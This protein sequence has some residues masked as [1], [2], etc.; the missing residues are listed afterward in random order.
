MEKKKKKKT[1]GYC[2][3]RGRS[4]NREPN[5]WRPGE[6]LT[7]KDHDL[8]SVLIRRYN[9]LGYVPSQRE[10]PNARAIKKRFRIWND[11]VAA[12]GLPTCHTSIQGRIR[13]K[14]QEWEDRMQEI[15]S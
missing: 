7:A 13:A 4:Y 1:G 10:A 2:Y 3:Y 5:L 12:A 8:L 9:Q 14:K 6:P 15:L 11:A